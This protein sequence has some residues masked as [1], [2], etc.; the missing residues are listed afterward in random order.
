MK[1]KAVRDRKAENSYSSYFLC[2]AVSMRNRCSRLDSVRQPPLLAIFSPS[3][4]N[5]PGVRV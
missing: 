3:S 2:S 1:T 4:A 5:R